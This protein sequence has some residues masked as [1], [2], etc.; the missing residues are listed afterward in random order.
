LVESFNL[1]F[2]LLLFLQPS[3]PGILWAFSVPSLFLLWAFSGP[4]LG[5][6]WAKVLLEQWRGNLAALLSNQVSGWQKLVTQIGDRL[7]SET[8][9]VAAAHCA[10]L[11][12]GDFPSP[13]L[14]LIGVGV[15]SNDERLI[16]EGWH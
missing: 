3:A 5:L 10:Y 14:S 2:C 9:D 16:G 15:R 11:V 1:V 7:L 12:A 13:K 4:S 8:C 6:L